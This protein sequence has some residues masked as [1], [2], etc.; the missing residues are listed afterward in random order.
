MDS[1]TIEKVKVDDL[2]PCEKN[3][4][5]D[6]TYRYG[7]EAEELKESIHNN[8]VINPVIVRPLPNG[9]EGKTY[10]IISGNRRVAACK[11]LGQETVPAIVEEMDDDQ[12]VIVLVDSNLQRDDILPS[13]KGA[14]YRMKLE[15]IKRQGIKGSAQNGQNMTS[16]QQVAAQAKESK[17]QIQRYIRLTYLDKHYTDLVDKKKLALVTA[18]ELSYLT[19]ANQELLW[20]VMQTEKCIPTTSQATT[21]REFNDMNELNESKIMEIL[22]E[23]NQTGDKEV[24]IKVKRIRKYFPEQYSDKK[25]VDELYQILNDYRLEQKNSKESNEQLPPKNNE[26]IPRKTDEG[27][28][29]S[30]Q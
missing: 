3:P 10:E 25:I 21:I 20:S 6:E 16:V 27:P 13:E 2:I 28:D 17:T 12:A 18:V 7:T 8:G 23:K 1:K 22:S 24:V 11:S 14:A 29:I 30:L 5:K 9:K 15:A 19:P 26:N 4:Y